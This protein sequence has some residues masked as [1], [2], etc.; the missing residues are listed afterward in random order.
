MVSQLCY[1]R[2]WSPLIVLNVHTV[3][4]WI[5]VPHAMRHCDCSQAVDTA[6]L[7]NSIVVEAEPLP[8]CAPK[9]SSRCPMPVLLF[10]HTSS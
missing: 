10:S 3:C 2:L 1:R 7:V 8:Q 6:L 4:V 5:H 9:Y